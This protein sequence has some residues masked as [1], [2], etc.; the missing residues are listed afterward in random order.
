VE[1]LKLISDGG[2]SGSK[3]CKRGYGGAYGGVWRSLRF[4]GV[5]ILESGTRFCVGAFGRNLVSVAVK[6][7]S[8]LIYFIKK[9]CK[10]TFNA[11]CKDN[12]AINRIIVQHRKGSFPS[13][14]TGHTLCYATLF[15]ARFLF[16][17]YPVQIFIGLLF[18]LRIFV[19]FL[20]HSRIIPEQSFILATVAFIRMLTY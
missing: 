10:C 2:D 9:F 19:L 4:T 16:A 20:S 8:H 7:F 6:M 11:I 5:W 15:Y 12:T 3:K 18:I 1:K 13:T 17:G 14:L